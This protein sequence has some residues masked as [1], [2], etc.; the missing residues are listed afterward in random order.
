M[1]KSIQLHVTSLQGRRESNEDVEIYDLNL[2]TNGYAKNSAR[3]P[4][5][6]FLICDGHGGKEVAKFASNLLQELFMKKNLKY[7]LSENQIYHIFNSIQNDLINHLF[8]IGLECGCT[9]LIVI[10]YSVNYND[11]HIQVRN[12]GDSR[13]VMS[14]QGVARSL[15]KD[16]KPSWPD[17]KKRICDVNKKYNLNE[18]IYFDGDWRI[19]DLSVSR[20]FG[21]IKATPHVTHIPDIFKYSLNPDDEFIIMACD[22]LW[23]VMQ[24]H[25]AVNFVKDH[26]DNNKIELYDIPGKYPNDESRTSK[27]IARKLASYA[28]AIGSTDNISILIIIFD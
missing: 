27:S 17:E 28:I 11:K 9:A 26:L 16:H 22:G 5:D 25:E 14:T 2:L 6:F 1:S 8:K 4:I 20:A 3:A 19:H 7:P 24:N 12:L 18:E 15:T 23:D 10:R 13:A 21:D